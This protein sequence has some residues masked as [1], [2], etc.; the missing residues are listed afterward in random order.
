M[1]VDNGIWQFPDQM[2]VKPY[3]GFIYVI[4]DKVLNKAYLGKKYYWGKGKLNKGEPL[5]WKNYKTSSKKVKAFLKDGKDEEFE[6]I[7]LEQ[8]QT[9]GGLSYA[10]TWSL[11]RL[12]TPL[13]D[14]W[15]NSR[16]EGISWKVKEGVSDRHLQRL[17]DVIKLLEDK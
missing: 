14:Q 11:C 12:D 7:V 8:Y 15:L 3:E 2:G 6:F 1:T 9:K 5:P 10:E 4:V 17:Y 13:S 16:I